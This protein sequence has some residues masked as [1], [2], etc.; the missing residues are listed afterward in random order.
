MKSKIK[1][2]AKSN[3]QS[4]ALNINEKLSK[5]IST[6]KNWNNLNVDRTVKLQLDSLNDLI[7]KL[8][9]PHTI[10]EAKNDAEF[11]CK[12]LFAGSAKGKKLAAKLIGKQNSLDVYRINLSGLVSNYTNETEKNIEKLFE[13]AE[14]K[15][16]ILFFDEADALFGKRTSVKDAHDRYANQNMSHLIQQINKYPGLIIFSTKNNDDSNGEYPI[17]LDSVIHFKKPS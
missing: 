14:E 1:S 17:H 6:K 5:R 4:L 15:N 12:V 2:V 3:L 13:V 9:I 11:G 16:W 10:D 8:N 7:P